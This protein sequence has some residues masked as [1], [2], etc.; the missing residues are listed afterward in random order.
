LELT[1]S[2]PFFDISLRC[3][4]PLFIDTEASREWKQKLQFHMDLLLDKEVLISLKKEIQPCRDGFC[5]KRWLWKYN[6]KL[7]YSKLNQE[8]NRRK[9]G[10]K[11][12]GQ[13]TKDVEEFPENRE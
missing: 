13:S 9:R 6:G 2:G 7:T 11:V 4:L 3:Y 10:D 12:P 5:W 1:K 8:E